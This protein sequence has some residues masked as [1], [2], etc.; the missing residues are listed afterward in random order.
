MSTAAS[1]VLAYRPTWPTSPSRPTACR[2]VVCDGCR[3]ASTRAHKKIIKPTSSRRSWKSSSSSS[4]S[5][6]GTIASSTTRASAAGAT[7]DGETTDDAITDDVRDRTSAAPRPLSAVIVGGGIGGLAAAVALRRVG[8]DAHV[9]ERALELRS[10]VGTGIALWPN[11]VNA[12]RTIGPDVAQEV[13]SRGCD[14]TGMRMG[15]VDEE[16]EQMRASLGAAVCSR[17][18]RIRRVRRAARSLP[19]HTFGRV[20]HPLSACRCCCCCCLRIYC[21]VVP[22]FRR[23]G[24]RVERAY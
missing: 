14:I 20:D 15:V 9:Y 21:A 11:G 1:T 10:N 24:A 19:P 7:N 5:F 12:L 17:R 23:R 8:I 4:S 3:L 22:L 18:R 16:Q 6:T 2:A 13:A